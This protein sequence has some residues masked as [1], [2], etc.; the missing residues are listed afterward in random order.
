MYFFDDSEFLRP[1]NGG[2]D[3]INWLPKLAPRLLTL[4]DVFRFQWC[5]PVI[6]SPAP[7]AIGRFLDNDASQHNIERWGKVRAID[8]MPFG[9]VTAKDRSR[10]FGIA[11]SL[12]FTG[13][14]IYPDW[15]PRPGMHL[16]VRIDRRPGCPATW[17]GVDRNG[18]QEYINIFDVLEKPL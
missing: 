5:A 13:I 3:L 4:L 14:G 11:S 18:K 7:G 10:A 2:G 12:G 15:S 16:D 8:V 9:M 17:A 1:P 6:I